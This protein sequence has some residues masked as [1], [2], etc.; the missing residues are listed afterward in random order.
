MRPK[1][2]STLK[3]HKRRGL[4]M[5]STQCRN[6]PH[7]GHSGPPAHANT[8]FRS[9]R[10][11][12]LIPC[13][14]RNLRAIVRVQIEDALPSRSRVWK[15]DWGF[16]KRCVFKEERIECFQVNL[17]RASSSSSLSLSLSLSLSGGM[18]TVLC[19]RLIDCCWFVKFFPFLL[20]WKSRPGNSSFI[21][22]SS[23]ALHSQMRAFYRHETRALAAQTANERLR[24]S[25]PSFHNEIGFKSIA[26]SSDHSMHTFHGWYFMTRERR[27]LD[28]L[29]RY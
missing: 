18:P 27:E 25:T 24:G 20:R 4:T 11:V 17:P 29:C 13:K 23:S 2:R 15:Q 21:H 10:R 12:F 22:A 5:M 16:Y 1:H 9:L 6:P 28:V 3:I 8:L 19:S 14:L 7:I 26:Q